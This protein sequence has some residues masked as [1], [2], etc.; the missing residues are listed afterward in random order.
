MTSSRL[1]CSTA[2]KSPRVGRRE[3][4]TRDLRAGMTIALPFRDLYL[5]WAVLAEPVPVS[6]D[7]SMVMIRRVHQNRSVG[8]PVGV[9]LAP[10]AL[11]DQLPHHYGVCVRCGG[12]SPCIDE[13]VE[14]TLV[15][16]EGMPAL[17]SP[18]GVAK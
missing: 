5:P 18:E 16:C 6:S 1:L 8:V 7:E 11:V 17:V 12:L 13:W 4:M 10:T 14:S 15:E 3:I 9:R 2:W